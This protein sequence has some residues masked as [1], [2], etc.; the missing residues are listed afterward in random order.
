MS[1]SDMKE[2]QDELRTNER[3]RIAEWVDTQT[4][5]ERLKHLN[6]RGELFR[7]LREEDV[8]HEV[9]VV[10]IS[11]QGLILLTEYATRDFHD[12]DKRIKKIAKEVEGHASI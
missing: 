1:S 3:R 7:K 4:M 10:E 11:Q 12:I 6:T 9:A 2:N 8:R 5:L